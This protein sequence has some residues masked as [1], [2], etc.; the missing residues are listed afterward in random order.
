MAAK[1][2]GPL[3]EY[4]AAKIN[5]PAT[6][7]AKVN[8][9]IT[10][11]K[12]MAQFLLDIIKEVSKEEPAFQKIENMSGFNNIIKSIKIIAGEPG[13]ADASEKPSSPSD[14]KPEDIVAQE[15]GLREAYNRIK[16]K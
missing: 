8:S 9:S 4:D 5:L 11:S 6:F 10:N 12:N 16:R 7:L 13:N 2:A 1:I 3:N 15:S 14:A